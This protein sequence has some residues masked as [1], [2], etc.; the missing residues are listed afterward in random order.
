[1][2]IDSTYLSEENYKEKDKVDNIIGLGKHI[3]KFLLNDIQIEFQ[4]K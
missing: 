4:K 1:M 3:P 2:K